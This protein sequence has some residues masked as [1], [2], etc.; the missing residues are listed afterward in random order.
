VFR[1]YPSRRSE[2]SKY[3]TV[4]G[5]FGSM[6]LFVYHFQLQYSNCKLGRVSRGKVTSYKNLP[7][8]KMQFI[9]AC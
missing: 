2:N 1:F 9:T 6:F 4:T 8:E 3:Q 5:N 7:S